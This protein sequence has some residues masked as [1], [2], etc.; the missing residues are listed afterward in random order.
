MPIGEVN[1]NRGPFA[2][3]KRFYLNWSG[4]AIVEA[5]LLDQ[6]PIKNL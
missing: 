3:I 6:D 1:V 4:C 5:H 2:T